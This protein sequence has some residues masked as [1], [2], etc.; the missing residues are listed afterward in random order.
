MKIIVIAQ[1]VVIV[2]SVAVTAISTGADTSMSRV[3]LPL[4]T[5]AQPPPVIPAIEG[6]ARSHVAYVRKL[7]FGLGNDQRAVLKIG[8]SITSSTHFLTELADDVTLAPED[9]RLTITWQRYRHSFARRSMASVG[10]A[11][12]H[13]I[14]D[15]SC[16]TAS[17]LAC[18]IRANPGAVALVMLGTNEVSF[19]TPPDVYR[20]QMFQVVDTLERAGIVPVISTIP[21]RRISGTNEQVQA[22]NTVLAEVAAERR[23]PLWNYWLSMTEPTLIDGGLADGLHPNVAPTGAADLTPAATRYG[24]NRRNL[25]ALRVLDAIPPPAA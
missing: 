16:W 10:G 2:A 20:T 13:S 21:P 17:L 1:A 18:E 3:Y 6:A 15:P 12:A 25:E 19:Q 8:D 11:S 4:G 9:G 24:Y 22:L 7:G 5:L 23:A 14:L